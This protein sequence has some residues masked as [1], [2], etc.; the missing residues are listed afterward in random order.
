MQ[1][2]LSRVASVLNPC[3]EQKD[4]KMVACHYWLKLSYGPVWLAKESI[5]TNGNFVGF[6]VKLNNYSCCDLV[7]CEILHIDFGI[8][9]NS[10]CSIQDLNERTALETQIMEFGQTP[11]RLF[12]Q[13][14]PQRTISK[15]RLASPM[16]PIETIY[17]PTVGLAID[18]NTL[19]CTE[20]GRNNANLI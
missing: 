9:F 16:S 12:T 10:C 1:L 14:H 7:L 3:W 13:P 11:K 15:S 5:V 18:T 20:Q 17:D 6:W 8:V 4:M 2:F 19:G